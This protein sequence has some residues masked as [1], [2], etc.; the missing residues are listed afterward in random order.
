M[1]TLKY[2]DAPLEARAARR[3][4]SAGDPPRAAPGQIEREAEQLRRDLASITADRES[5]GMK[6]EHFIRLECLKLAVQIQG[7]A[8]A[9]SDGDIASD[10]VEVAKRF[11]DFVLD[12]PILQRP[13][14]TTEEM[15]SQALLDTAEFRNG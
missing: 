15:V 12:F 10:P 5:N 2:F 11:A 7:Q 3:Q 4:A 14:P 8:S 1:S 6:P 9:P 13:E